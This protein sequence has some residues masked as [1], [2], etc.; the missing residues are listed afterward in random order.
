LRAI[1][2]SVET[3]KLIQYSRCSH[4]CTL[5]FGHESRLRNL[6]VRNC[7]PSRVWPCFARL[8]NRTLKVFR[9]RMEFESE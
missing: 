1:P 3:L 6:E 8:S 9:T 5:D 2:D 7:T 4:S